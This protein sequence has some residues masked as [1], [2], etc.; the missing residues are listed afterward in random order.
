M[1][2]IRESHI[3]PRIVFFPLAKGFNRLVQFARGHHVIHRSD[4]QLFA[5]AGTVAQRECLSQIFFATRRLPD[6]AIHNADA[7]DGTSKIRIQIDGTLEK[8]QSRRRSLF[9][10]NFSAY[11][12]RLQSFQRGRGFLRQRRIEFLH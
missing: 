3:I 11:A 5:L 4:V 1:P 6:V 12:R 10:L 7:F 2:K 8:R 9:M